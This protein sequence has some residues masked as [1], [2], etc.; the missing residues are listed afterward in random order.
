M[1]LVAQ[2]LALALEPAVNWLA[3]RGWRRGAATGFVML[4]V[5][6]VLG[7]F[8]VAVGSLVVSQ[9]ATLAEQAP[10]YRRGPAE[11]D[12][13]HVRREPVHGTDP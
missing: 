8:V 5:L 10:D 4:V 6:G 1:L 9:V 12:Q 2:F 11:L 3:A 7:V 13:P